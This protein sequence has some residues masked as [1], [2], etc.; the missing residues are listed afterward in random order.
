MMM[1][2]ATLKQRHLVL[3]SMNVQLGIILATRN[4]HIVIISLVVINANVMM[5]LKVM[6]DHVSPSITAMIRN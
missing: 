6:D 1:T 2:S 3:I 4:M 5:D